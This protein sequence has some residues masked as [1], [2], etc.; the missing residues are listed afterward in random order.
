MNAL[1]AEFDSSSSQV[2]WASLHHARGSAEGTPRLLRSL[3]AG[4]ADAAASYGHLWS[5]L[6]GESQ[7]WGATAPAAY[8]LSILVRDDKFG[9]DDKTL[10]EGTLVFFRE[11]ALTVP[12]EVVRC[13][14]V[15][16]IVELVTSA[17]EQACGLVIPTLLGAE[18]SLIDDPSSRLASCASTAAV[19][20]VTTSECS[21]QSERRML[22]ESLKARVHSAASSAD[23]AGALLDLGRIGENLSEFLS[24]RDWGTR[25]AAALG[26]TDSSNPR[27]LDVLLDAARRS[28]E[29]DALLSP[30]GDSSWM[31]LP[32][33]GG[34]RLPIVVA[35]EVC[36]RVQDLG[37]L[38]QPLIS[39]TKMTG[40]PG[41]YL[42]ARPYYRKFFANGFPAMGDASR[43]QMEIACLIATSD[44]YWRQPGWQRFLAGLKLP[45]SRESWQNY[46][47]L[48][49]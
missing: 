38:V 28:S 39:A 14:P 12:S 48:R 7:V 23:R 43:Y 47:Q 31:T 1:I 21:F 25:L 36:V 37:L 22:I 27:V 18:L 49:G 32:Q 45:T 24:E 20:A 15:S 29:L 46:C 10:R 11:L 41:G 16:S 9:G 34:R 26:S 6:L 33:L 4:G 8:L 5:D 40:A 30:P 42:V 17:P 35:E 44:E 19:A 13:S 2:S 3:W